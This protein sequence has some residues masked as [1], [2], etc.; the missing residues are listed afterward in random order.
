MKA[1]DEHVGRQ[2]RAVRQFRNIK[3]TQMSEGLDLSYQQ[4]Q[5][6]QTGG[7]RLSASRMYQ[8]ASF[9]KVSPSFFFDG[10]PLTKTEPLPILK[11]EHLDLIRSYETIPAKSR[12]NLLR[13]VK[14]MGG[15]NE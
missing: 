1:I 10:L 9:L 6:Y 13:I 5:K 15:Q 11:K 14:I 3:L 4:F 8:I 2:F 12:K 7:D